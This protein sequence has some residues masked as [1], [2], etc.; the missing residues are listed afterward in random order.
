MNT[1][2]APGGGF[3]VGAAVPL[4]PFLAA[5]G[6]GALLAAG[7]VSLLA[8]FSMGAAKSLITARSAL[9]S[10]AEM[11]VIGACAAVVTNVVGRLLGSYA[12][13]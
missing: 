12:G 13:G 8:L 4:I 10:G 7:I 6:V 3:A 11:V 5:G 9:R 1:N 2:G